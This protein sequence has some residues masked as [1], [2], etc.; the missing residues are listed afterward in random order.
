MPHENNDNKP[1][2]RHIASFSNN[3][4]F[5][6]LYEGAGGIIGL[7]DAEFLG[8]DETWISTGPYTCWGNK[9]QTLPRNGAREQ[10]VPGSAIFALGPN[11]PGAWR[12]RRN[13][14]WVACAGSS[15]LGWAVIRFRNTTSERME[16]SPRDIRI[17]LSFLLTG[18][19]SFDLSTWHLAEVVILAQNR[20]LRRWVGGCE[21][22]ALGDGCCCY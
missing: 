22:A 16:A 8:G 9:W 19:E 21:G 13:Q 7:K 6:T 2:R 15:K 10:E 17:D 1:S 3:F 11:V 18:S 5:P 4:P 12:G 14:G 20:R